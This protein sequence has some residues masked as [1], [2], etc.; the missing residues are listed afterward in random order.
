MLRFLPLLLVVA[1]ENQYEEYN[2]LSQTDTFQQEPISEV[3]I[4]FVIDNSVS[5]QGEQERVASGFQAFIDSMEGSNID[6]HIGVINTDMDADNG[7]RGKL[8]GDPPYLTPDDDYVRLFKQRVKVGTDG[9]DKEKGL[10]ASLRAVT[11]PLASGANFGFM[12]PDA[13][14]SV[15]YVADE[16]DCSDNDALSDQPGSACY[17]QADQ[18]IPVKELVADL[19]AV[20]DDGVRVLASA[21]VG[22]DL[23]SAC[24]ESWP[25]TRYM[26]AAN[27][28][29]G[30]IGNICD[31]DYSDIM[32]E[33]GLEASGILSTFQLTKAAV[34]GTIEVVVDSEAVAEDAATGWTYDAD[35]WL[36]RFDGSYLPPRGATISV[37][38]EVAGGGPA[39]ELE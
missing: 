14:L 21:I 26:A 13:T 19:K 9:S 35:Y 39:P 30:L 4:L 32:G 38:Y 8:I 33:L 17:N 5:M 6:F 2:R 27:G 36:I 11:E 3:D 1:C 34:E 22:P 25:G 29:G 16:N 18:L 28:T 20:K 7:D 24:E 37:T 10:S 23:D 12:R 15:I 31:A